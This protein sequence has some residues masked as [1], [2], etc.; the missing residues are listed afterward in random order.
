LQAYQD[1]GMSPADVIRTATI[2]GADLMG[3]GNRVGSIEPGKRADIIAVEGDPLKNVKDLRNIRF[4][5]KD[6]SVVPL[7]ASRP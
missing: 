5:M 1:A 6:G 7:P 3:V 2:N 4:V